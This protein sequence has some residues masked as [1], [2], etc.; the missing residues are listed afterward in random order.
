MKVSMVVICTRL[1][2]K[3]LNIMPLKD[4]RLGLYNAGEQSFWL[5]EPKGVR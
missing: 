1:P 5:S 2:E 4:S 3:V